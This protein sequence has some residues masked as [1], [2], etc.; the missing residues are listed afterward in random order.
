MNMYKF[1]RFQLVCWLA[2]GHGIGGDN[3]LHAWR[4]NKVMQLSNTEITVLE[5]FIP[6]FQ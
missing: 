6:D 2:A 5:S 4:R 1:H 3:S